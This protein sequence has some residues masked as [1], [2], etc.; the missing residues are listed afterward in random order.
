VNE[1]TKKLTGPDEYNLE[2]LQYMRKAAQCTEAG[3]DPGE[4]AFI[5]QFSFVAGPARRGE[6]PREA[7]AC[8][9]VEAYG[10]GC[11]LD[12]FGTCVI[13]RSVTCNSD[14]ELG[15]VKSPMRVVPGNSL[16]TNLEVFVYLL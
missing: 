12:S 10:T 2:Y 14:E 13:N 6:E 15:F 1:R 8:V 3:S 16:G 5:V 9:S 4:A 7:S 11:V